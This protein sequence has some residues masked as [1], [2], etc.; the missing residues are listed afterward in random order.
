[1]KRPETGV[2][3]PCPCCG[4]E[5]ELKEARAYAFSGWRVRCRKCNLRT[6]PEYIDCPQLTADGPDESTRYTSDQAAEI[7]TRLWNRRTHTGGGAV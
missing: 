1:M 5:A 7:V 4:G 6:K 2:L 3:E